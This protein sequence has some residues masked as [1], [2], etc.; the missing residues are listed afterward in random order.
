MSEDELDLDI[1][2]VTWKKKGTSHLSEKEALLTLASKK[3]EF[4]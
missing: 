1:L 4:L 3:D 2:F